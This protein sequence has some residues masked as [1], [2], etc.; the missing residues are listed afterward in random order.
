MFTY[1]LSN[2]NVTRRTKMPR[3]YVVNVVNGTL[4]FL[5]IRIVRCK[6][7]NLL[8]NERYSKIIIYF[9]LKL[10]VKYR[11]VVFKFYKYFSEILK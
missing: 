11:I 6:T 8:I 5:C 10:Y 9:E 4:Y 7:Q 3:Y 1:N 2:V